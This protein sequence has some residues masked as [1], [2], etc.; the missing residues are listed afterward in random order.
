MN[1]IKLFLLGCW[2]SL[3]LVG[4]AQAE[5]TLDP[6]NVVENVDCDAVNFIGGEGQVTLNNLD[7]PSV[8]IEYFGAPTNYQTVV[9]CNG[10]CATTQVISG[11]ASGT[12]IVKVLMIG[13]AGA[14]CFREESVVVTE[15]M[16]NICDGQGGDA[17]GDGV[18]ADVDCDDTDAA[19]GAR[20]IPGT[21]CDDGN[22]NTN[23]DVIRAD[24][25]TCQGVN[26]SGGTADCDIVI[27]SGGAG[28]FTLNN[29]FAQSERIEYFG[30]PTG[31]QTIAACD[32]NCMEVQSVTGLIAGAYV[33]KLLM[34]GDDGS[35][36]Y[37]E[38]EVVVTGINGDL[39]A[40]NG[41]DADFDG[42]CADMDCDDNNPF[43]GA[44]QTPGTSCNDG[45]PNTDND[46]IQQDGCTC[47]GEVDT[48][49]CAGRGGDADGDGICADEDCDDTQANIGIAQAP[50]TSCDDGNPNTNNDI[51]LQDGCTCLGVIDGALCAER[52]GDADSDGICADID[53]DDSRAD[54][55]GAQVPG[56]SCDDGNPNT[57]ND[58]IQSDGCTCLGAIDPTF[59][60]QRGGDADG[61]GVCADIDCDDNAAD[62]GVAQVVGT[63]CDDGNPNTDNDV[64]QADGCMCLGDVVDCDAVIFEGGA[65]TITVSNLTA[66][67]V[68]L[69]II[70]VPTNFELINICNGECNVQQIIPNLAPGLYS[71]KLLLGGAGGCY[72]EEDVIVT[73]SSAASSSNRTST[74]FHL[75]GFANLQ[76]IE[77]QWVHTDNRPKNYFVLEKSIDGQL[78]EPVQVIKSEDIGTNVAAY[79]EF[80]EQPQTGLNYYRIGTA[81]STGDFTYSEVVQVDFTPL[82]QFGLF[83]N[84]V[85]H[86]GELFIN[87]SDFADKSADLIIYNG[88]GQQ[89]QSMRVDKVGAS[90]IRLKLEG[91]PD[92][93]Y[94]IDV[95]VPGKRLQAR[96]F[97]VQRL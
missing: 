88:F 69:N 6:L 9:V 27:F 74:E 21:S 83:P 32:G 14:L 72:R 93:V 34:I 75:N 58:I 56:T 33:V 61:D 53:C 45:N 30:A 49:V 11:L 13:E 55:G 71:V 10:N 2:C 87:L 67:S 4:S 7:A 84:P 48:G 28:Q 94:S 29:L 39:C 15:S 85:T 8:S 95:K 80:D 50:G 12:Y 26:A 90:P 63:P 31:Y 79:K 3:I 97:V 68:E 1:K 70:G 20:Q 73:P 44:S 54:I 52:G 91:I 96:R 89:V 22:S 16:G 40:G 36:C 77:V 59:C 17:D 38:E 43:I 60:D 62:I 66:P 64:I 76:N 19:V 57:E 47:L 41:G 23:N 37:R 82:D 24:G 5:P 18:C 35:F 25:C 51:I 65:G 42:I 86:R 92:G 81:F 46:I 78:F